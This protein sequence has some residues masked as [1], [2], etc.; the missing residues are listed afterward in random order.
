MTYTCHKV[1]GWRINLEVVAFFSK[2]FF[3]LSK[4]LAEVKW[5]PKSYFFFF[6]I[7]KSIQIQS[8]SFKFL[9]WAAFQISFKIIHLWS[10]CSVKFSASPGSKL[11]GSLQTGS[12]WKCTNTEMSV[13]V[14]EL[15]ISAYLY[16]NF[17][18]LLDRTHEWFCSN[19]TQPSM[20]TWTRLSLYFAK[21][22][23]LL[24]VNSR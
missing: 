2:T 7:F 22:P 3:L 21:L 23:C 24:H 17:E 6:P 14:K 8:N 5:N 9:I 4:H 13:R 10:V 19:R 15:A 18:P 20:S 11:L 1:K 16:I 12:P